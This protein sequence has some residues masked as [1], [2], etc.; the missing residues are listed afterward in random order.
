MEFHLKNKSPNVVDILPK[1]TLNSSIKVAPRYS[2]L[3]PMANI[4]KPN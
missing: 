4:V 2:S 1:T 3:T